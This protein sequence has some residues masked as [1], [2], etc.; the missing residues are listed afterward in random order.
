[1]G[2][3]LSEH[4]LDASVLSREMVTHSRR[5]AHEDLMEALGPVEG[6]KG[7][8]VYICGPPGMTDEFVEVMGGAEGMDGGRVFCEKWW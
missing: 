8:V 2:P 6:R 5:I 3:S 4:M 7:M 1:M